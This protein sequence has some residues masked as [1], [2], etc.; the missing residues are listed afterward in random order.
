MSWNNV[1]DKHKRRFDRNFVSC[2][3]AYEKKYI[4]DTI[5]EEFPYFNR[6]NVGRVVDHCC[7]IMRSPRPRKEFLDCVSKNI[8]KV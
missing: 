6:N 8:G 4:I 2:E 7:Q 3:E 5:M 1:D